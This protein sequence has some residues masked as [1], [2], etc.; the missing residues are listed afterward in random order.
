MVGILLSGLRRVHELTS[1]E[2]IAQII[3]GG[4]RWLVSDTY[5]PGQ[6]HFRYTPC[7]NLGEHCSGLTYTRQVIEGLSY[8][9]KLTEDAV[10]GEIIKDSLEDL[11]E[12]RKASRDPEHRSIGNNLCSETRSVPALLANVQSLFQ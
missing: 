8:A 2:R 4:V 1:D 11:G 10:V 9:Y 5:D 12:P 7:P 6:K 3:E